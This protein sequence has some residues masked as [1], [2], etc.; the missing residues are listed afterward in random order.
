VAH[1]VH[2]VAVQGEPAQPPSQVGL[3]PVKTQRLPPALDLAGLRHDLGDVVRGLHRVA[4]DYLLGS[5]IDH[6]E[7]AGSGSGGG[8]P[9]TFSHLIHLGQLR[10]TV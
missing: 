6:I 3:P 2:L 7:G 9:G 10:I 1:L 5:G 8:L 4:A